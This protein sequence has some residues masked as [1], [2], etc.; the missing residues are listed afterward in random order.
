MPLTSILTPDQRAEFDRRG[1]LRLEGLLS[2]DAVSRARGA[3]LRPLEQ[4]GLWR[5]G[6]W[7]LDPARKAPWP[8][9]GP[10]AKA[11]G[12]KHAAVEALLDE[13]ALLAAVDAL[14]DGRAFDRTTNK[15]PQVLFTL[16]NAGEWTVPTGWH[17][18]F[19]RLASGQRP[20][21]QLFAFL[22]TVEPHGG[23][24]L[25]LAGSHRLL[26]IGRFLRNA[27]IRRLL[28]REAFLGEL[29]DEARDDRAQLMRKTG[30]V[31][32]VPL[33]LVELTGAP[34]DAWLMDLRTLHTGAPNVAERP[35]MMVTYRFVRTDLA[36]ELAATAY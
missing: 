6:A 12:N 18:D 35:R 17:V 19:A 27:D 23:G 36:A 30:V 25:V 34:G 26:N 4:L 33:E 14:L 5:D 15:R 11:I 7:R 10:S 13:P 3:V 9:K 22:E 29:Y 31:D 32:D 1:V 8:D 28:R 24:T 16:P 2:V 21:V 20:G